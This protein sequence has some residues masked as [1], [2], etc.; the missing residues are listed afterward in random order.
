MTP[1][2]L[3]GRVAVGA[4]QRLGEIGRVLERAPQRHFRGH[5]EDRHHEQRVSREPGPGHPR[6]PP[7]EHRAE[8]ALAHGPLPSLSSRYPTPR[9]VR[10]VAVRPPKLRFLRRESTYPSPT[11]VSGSNWYFH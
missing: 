11:L 8:P 10:I 4:E 3:A 9:T 5:G 1:P 2:G 6:E 7:R